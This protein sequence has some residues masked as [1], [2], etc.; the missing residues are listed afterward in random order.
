MN[1]NLIWIT[2]MLK[3]PVKPTE[4]ERLREL[5]RQATVRAGIR[6]DRE[7]KAAQWA[8]R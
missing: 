8:K 4:E 1:E 6:A 3:T 5:K 7:R 2:E